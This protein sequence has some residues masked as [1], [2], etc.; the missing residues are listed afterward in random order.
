MFP[1]PVWMICGTGGILGKAS[2]HF[3]KPGPFCM[4]TV[5][6]RCCPINRTWADKEQEAF[7]AVRNLRAATLLVSPLGALLDEKNS[8]QSQKELSF[9]L[10][11]CCIRYLLIGSEQENEEVC[12]GLSH[13]P[14]IREGNNVWYLEK[15]LVHIRIAPWHC[16]AGENSFLWLAYPQQ[17]CC[18]TVPS[19][20]SCCPASCWPQK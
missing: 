4:K 20:Q 3:F 2:T 15:N 11:W 7:W 19:D 14:C 12:T 5:D 13:V 10:S 16:F 6:C 1:V 18:T 8:V 9:H 17:H